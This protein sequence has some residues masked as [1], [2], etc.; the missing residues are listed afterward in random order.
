M[1]LDC[2]KYGDAS[3][4]SWFLAMAGCTYS[5]GIN[6]G[7]TTGESMKIGSE[8]FIALIKGHNLSS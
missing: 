5:M 4:S 3:C 6:S 7:N 1:T 8:L 2:T